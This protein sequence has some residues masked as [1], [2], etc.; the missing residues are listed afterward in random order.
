M[1]NFKV[2]LL[3]ICRL[4]SKR[5]NKK[6][7]KEVNGK[8]ILEILIIRLLNKFN[9]KQIVICSSVLSK[10]VKF[11]KLS[12]KYKVKLFY[13]DNKD[14]FFRMISAAKKYNFSNVVRI[15][16]DN[17]LTDI[18]AITK[19]TNSH[20]K[21]KSDFTYT[22][23]LMIG[24]RP[25]IL[26]VSALEK[27][28]VLAHDRYSSEYMTYFFLRKKQFKVNR[29]RFKEIIRNQ[30]RYCVTVDYLKEYFLLKKI[31][32]N[33]NYNINHNEV[34][35]YLQK[36]NVV[37]KLPYKRFIPTVTKKYNA[38]LKTDNNLNLI[39]LQKFGFK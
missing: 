31:L 39:D 13:G 6:I 30:N 10:N 14:I 27:C 19:M 22:T 21:K 36:N 7:L 37:K 8:S 32:K 29:V 12:K 9:N 38:S 28:R 2:G 34:L 35:K 17:P 20:L 1:L 11:R 24:T 15:T 33:G 16:G 23:N 5:L 4:N 18:D 25:E 26:K 3:I